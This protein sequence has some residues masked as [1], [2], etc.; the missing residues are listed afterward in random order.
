MIAIA[1]AVNGS[2]YALVQ[3]GKVVSTWPTIEEAI[4]AREALEGKPALKP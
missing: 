4:A 1:T 3:D 2:G